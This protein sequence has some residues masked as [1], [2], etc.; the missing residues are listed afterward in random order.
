MIPAH[1]A[2]LSVS[3]TSI[4]IERSAL[5]AALSGE[6]LVEVPLSSVTG[7]SAT[8]PSLVDA[9]RV[10]LEGADVA[11][12]FAPNQERAAEDFIADVEAALRG[13]APAAS[14]GGIT[15]LSF[16]GL[17]VETANMDVGSICQIGV[18]RIIDGVEVAAESWLCT[19][20]PGLDEFDPDNIAIHGITP[21]TVA[22]QPG[23]AERLPAL[24]DFIGDLPVVAHN[25]QFDMMALQR[26][27]EAGDVTVPTLAFGC[28][29]IL[30]RA[31]K[32]GIASHRLPVVAEVLGVP[33]GRH[34]DAMEDARAA[35][36][37]VVELAR[38]A[39][40][41]GTYTDFQHT[42]GFTMGTLN[43][44]RTW[45]VL[46]DRSGARIAMQ[47]VQPDVPV[48]APAEEK[49]APRRAPWQ[50]VSTPDVIPDPN[51]DADPSNPLF[52][53]HVTLTGD[54]EPF[55]KG[56]LWS[57]I[58]ELG[59]EIGKNVTRKTTVLVA[60]EWATKTSKEKRAEE[61]IDKGQEIQIWTSGQL[62]AVLGLD[63]QAPADDEQPPF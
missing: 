13:E 12:D 42:S 45:P 46:R 41:R 30:S 8:V 61:L 56:R 52:G 34:H 57:A 25:A 3:A 31:A 50:S 4:R 33:L 63:P 16:I 6:A 14:N 59:A 26:A 49:K 1:G 20:P 29:L 43:G 36:L 28:S 11:V 37:I 53:Q 60:G 55:D 19:P 5:A 15:G 58:A 48:A 35:A 22:G 62:F 54:F 18:V 24:L 40:H 2:Q 17:D 21:E 7:V 27:C 44:E 47:K 23:F 32:L 10:L 51:P 39:G 38:N 9:G